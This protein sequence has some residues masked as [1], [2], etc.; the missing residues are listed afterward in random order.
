MRRRAQ[1]PRDAFTIIE[2]LVVIGIIAALG[3]ML[4][5]AMGEARV[6]ARVSRAHGELRQVT[7]SLQLYQDCY[8]VFPPARTFCASQMPNID[9]YNHLPPELVRSRCIDSLPEDIFNPG[10]TYKYVAP[11]L[12]W[13]NGDLSILAIWVPNKFPKDTGQ[14]TPYFDQKSS[15]VKCAV[16]S[17]GPSGP[18]SVFDSDALRYP[19][20]PRYWYPNRRDGIIV[21]YYWNE[22]WR[23][24]P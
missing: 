23:S 11:G 15:P 22:C 14:E 2:V 12:G 19:M 6:A 4:L 16:W 20:P 9:D 21:H 17:V 7:I 24:S 5:P 1:A 13:A 3:A 8:N 10:H 18:K